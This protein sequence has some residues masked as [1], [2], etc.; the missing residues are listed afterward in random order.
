MTSPILKAGSAVL[1]EL[2]GSTQLERELQYKDT[3]G[4]TTS[5]CPPVC[6]LTVDTLALTASIILQTFVPVHAGGA[7][8]L[9]RPVE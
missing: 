3:P 6:P 2:S 9:Q 1:S 5:Q 7:L 4:H 8:A